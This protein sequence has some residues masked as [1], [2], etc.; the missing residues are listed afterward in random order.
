MSDSAVANQKQY[1]EVL[2][3]IGGVVMLIVVVVCA[4]KVARRA[5]ADIRS[6]RRNSYVSPAATR[7][8]SIAKADQAGCSRKGSAPR[9]GG[10][11]PRSGGVSSPEGSGI[12][13]QPAAA[14]TV[15]NA[16]QG[17]RSNTTKAGAVH[18]NRSQPPGPIPRVC[19]A[20]LSAPA[21]A[22]SSA[23]YV[24]NPAGVAASAPPG[25]GTGVPGARPNPVPTGRWTG[26]ALRA[27]I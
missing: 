4:C 25:T 2:L 14:A 15:P 24:V 9:G 1:Q 7:P 19:N 26:E 11:R 10:A 12:N 22:Q 16:G 13:V 3:V 21:A 6:F 27:V 17:A 5:R 23:G 8:R 20:T 18:N